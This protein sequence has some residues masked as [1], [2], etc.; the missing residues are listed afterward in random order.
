MALGLEALEHLKQIQ[1]GTGMTT[2]EAVANYY[3]YL[4]DFFSKY[5][6]VFKEATK[7][8]F[9]NWVRSLDFCNPHYNGKFKNGRVENCICWTK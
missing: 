5:D 7:E 2:G 1:P 8:E 3:S 9:Y 6:S 4:G